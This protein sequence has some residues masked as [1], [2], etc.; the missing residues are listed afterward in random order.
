MEITNSMET[1]KKEILSVFMRTMLSTMET[2][3]TKTLNFWTNAISRGTK[4][5]EDLEA[6]LIKSQDYQNAVQNIFVDIFYDQI[7][8]TTEYQSLLKDFLDSKKNSHISREDIFSFIVNSAPFIEKYTSIISNVYE[9]ISN[10][11]P[12]M[13]T[14]VGFLKKFQEGQYSVD[15]LKNDVKALLENIDT[16][17]Q[18]ET[19]SKDLTENQQKEILSLWADKTKF[20]EYY[21]HNNEIK[22]ETNPADPFPKSNK[23]ADDFISTFEK[24]YKRNMNA[25]EY[26]LYLPRYDNN[27]QLIAN[28]DQEVENLKAKHDSMLSQVQELSTKL[29]NETLS[30]DV[31]IKKYLSSID[32]PQFVQQLK[33]EMLQSDKYKNSMTERISS[34]YRTLYGEELGNEEQS[35]IFEQVKSKEYDLF[36]EDM[37]DVLVSYKNEN[38]QFIERIYQIFMETY[39][40]EPDVHEL[41]KYIQL[42]RSHNTFEPTEVDKVVENELFSSLEYHDVIKQKIR[43]IYL[44]IKETNILPSVIYQLLDKTLQKQDYKNMDRWLSQ[45]IQEL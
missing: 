13:E 5:L 22:H 3:D 19:W 2:M 7:G 17:S 4:T 26:I 28:L 42:Y 16:T 39:E 36:N 18:S 12:T 10:E 6:F 24:V 37:N 45:I 11:E 25:R 34:L 40:R 29:Y 35:Y 33:Y 20:V 21:R 32:E 38:D 23:F 14:I 31:F 8:S 9:T 44:E 27:F 30:E 41:S 43:K 15:D 1:I